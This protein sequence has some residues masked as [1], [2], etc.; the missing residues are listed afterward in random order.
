M[1]MTPPLSISMGGVF[2]LP[3]CCKGGFFIWRPLEKRGKGKQRRR[4]KEK[5]ACPGRIRQNP[6]EKNLFP[7]L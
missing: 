7:P 5:C 6:G 4:Q 1:G 2:L 3:P